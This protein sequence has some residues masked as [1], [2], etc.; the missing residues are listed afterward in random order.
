MNVELQI[1]EG[2]YNALA[3]LLAKA[4]TGDK[5]SAFL[6]HYFQKK[7][8]EGVIDASYDYTI[9]CHPDGWHAD[10]SFSFAW[11]LNNTCSMLIIPKHSPVTAFDRAMGVIGR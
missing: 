7:V 1:Q 3:E 9:I 2:I 11:N 8:S 5:A 6:S 10:V 4:D